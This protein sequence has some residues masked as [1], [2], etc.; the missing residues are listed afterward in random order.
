MKKEERERKI[1]GKKSRHIPAS[2]NE[3]VG[4]AADFFNTSFT[5]PIRMKQ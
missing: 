5:V 4:M 2:T 1:E 3:C